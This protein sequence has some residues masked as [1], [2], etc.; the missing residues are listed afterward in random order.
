MSP[1][2]LLSHVQKKQRRVYKSFTKDTI[3]LKDL[4]TIN[5]TLLI[6]VKSGISF[7][8]AFSILLDEPYQKSTIDILSRIEYRM[9]SGQSISMALS[10]EPQLFDSLYVKTIEYAEN[11]RKFPEVFARLVDFFE[12]LE[13][14]QARKNIVF[15]TLIPVISSCFF[16]A[17][18]LIANLG[19]YFDN[20]INLQG[21]VISSLNFLHQ[22]IQS[23]FLIFLF[24]TFIAGLLFFLIYLATS[25]ENFKLK[26]DQFMIRSPFSGTLISTYQVTLFLKSL[27]LLIS[28]DTP[29]IVALK[30]SKKYLRNEE[31]ITRFEKIEAHFC[32]GSSLSKSLNDE[33]FLPRTLIQIILMG[34]S[35]GNLNSAIQCA[36]L[37]SENSFND[38][39]KRLTIFLKRA[40]FFIIFL[41][42]FFLMLNFF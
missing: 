17:I 6:L 1:D 14:I 35:T 23:S 24:T 3:N 9:H 11:T 4:A 39:V 18:L 19:L 20:L 13:K 25:I 38:E 32:E 28:I 33:N 12:S 40:L 30:D 8:R 10:L 16:I 5:R 27:A 7:E 34:E 21:E 26:V 42:I 15:L 22:I 37:L 2:N 41:S 36:G 31:L 29:L